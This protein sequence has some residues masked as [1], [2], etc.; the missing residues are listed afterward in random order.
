VCNA[1]RRTTHSLLL[2]HLVEHCLHVSA[3][4]NTPPSTTNTGS[5]HARRRVEVFPNR[6]H[7]TRAVIHS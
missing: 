6:G 2:R 1:K 5:T 4:P 3:R 7:A